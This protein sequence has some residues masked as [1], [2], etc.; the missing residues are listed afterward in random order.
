MGWMVVLPQVL[1][2]TEDSL[3]GVSRDAPAWVTSLK[4]ELSSDLELSE[5]Q[6]LQVSIGALRN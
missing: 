1:P 4:T 5:E 6:R 3:P 2:Q